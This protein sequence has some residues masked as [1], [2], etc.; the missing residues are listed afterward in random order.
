MTHLS[1]DECKPCMLGIIRP[2][3]AKPGHARGLGTMENRMNLSC[4]Y[5]MAMVALVAVALG[6]AAWAQS[7][8]PAASPT[9][10]PSATPAPAPSPSPVPPPAETKSP[11]DTPAAGHTP[12][13][14][15]PPPPVPTAG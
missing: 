4:H 12:T 10:A 9:P 15:P 8:A 5:R 13:P 1:W 2:R 3:G 14:P 7:P 6:G 11:A